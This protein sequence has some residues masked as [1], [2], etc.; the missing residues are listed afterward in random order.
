MADPPTDTMTVNGRPHPVPEPGE[1]PLL[2]A[3][4]DQFGLLSAKY[5]CGLEQCGACVVLIDG[6]AEPSCRKP[7]ATLAGRQVQTLE[8]LR[9]DPV[10]NRVIDALTAA[11]AGQCGYC[12]PGI[13][14][15][16]IWLMRRAPVEWDLVLH[17]LNDHLCRCGSQPRILRVARLLFSEE[18][19]T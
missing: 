1:Q 9:D 19:T 13:T 16:L 18:G 3:L 17:S 2:W 6:V 4:R 10:A 14:I 8:G 11:N 15:R 7:V 12:L 5:G